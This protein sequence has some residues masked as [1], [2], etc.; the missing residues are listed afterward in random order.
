MGRTGTF[1]ALSALLTEQKPAKDSPLGPLWEEYEDDKVAQ[2][3][4]EIRD[5]RGM[6]VQG[7]EQLRLIYEVCK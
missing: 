3:V 2:V 5:W 1:I 6:L 7:P 4:D